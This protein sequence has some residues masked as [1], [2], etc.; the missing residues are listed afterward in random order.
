MKIAYVCYEDVGKYS[1]NVE[2]EDQILLDFLKDKGLN[3]TREVWNDQA[4]DWAAYDLALIK[5]PWD[6]FDQIEEF[7]RWLNKLDNLKLDLLN[8]ANIIRWNSD[9]HYLNE[10]AEAGLKVT[11]TLYFEKGERPDLNICFEKLQSEVLIV[12]PC[13][14]G[15]S[16]NTIKITRL[17]VEEKTSLV[18]GY[19][20]EEAYMVQPFLKEIET[21][22]EWS[23]LFFNG[24]FS[25]NLLKKA[26]PGDFRVQHYLGG[27]IHPEPAPPHLLKSAKEYVDQFAKGCLYARVDGLEINGE[28]VLMELELIE[29]F[30]FLFTNQDSYENY[31]IALTEMI[32]TRK[33]LLHQV[34]V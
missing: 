15:G 17:N 7:Y 5:S 1:S 6:Y 22:G 19:L 28:F 11:P 14:S 13:I 30:L 20:T 26:K 4:V 29:P 16:K 18:H 21:D 33:R 25:H 32:N 2:N 23:F 3:L 12:K 31:Y 10:I 24:T 8:P 27:S 9:K 34:E